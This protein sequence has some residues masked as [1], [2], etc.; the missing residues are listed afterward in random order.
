[1]NRQEIRTQNE[2][3]EI[4][5]QA[6]SLTALSQQ[7]GRVYVHLA[8]PELADRFL[9]QAEREGFRFPD[10][11]TPTNR[12]A[13][14]IMALNPDHTISYVG[15]IGHIAYGSGTDT[16]GGKLLIRIDYAEWCDVAKK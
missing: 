1:M 15:S 16:V 10:G 11:A 7:D 8:T 14:T 6:H 9:R 4:T 13:S 3:R 12:H 2:T 5:K